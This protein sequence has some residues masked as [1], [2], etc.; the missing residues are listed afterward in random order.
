MPVQVPESLDEAESEPTVLCGETRVIQVQ[1][2][3]FVSIFAKRKHPPGP[4]LYVPIARTID[5]AGGILPG[6]AGVPAV[7]IHGADLTAHLTDK[8]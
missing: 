3:S 6:L 4:A 7:P 1:S 2:S 8:C 5:R